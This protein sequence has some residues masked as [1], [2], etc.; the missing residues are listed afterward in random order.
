MVNIDGYTEPGRDRGR[1]YSMLV[2]I[3]HLG[4][5]IKHIDI[6]VEKLERCYNVKNYPLRLCYYICNIF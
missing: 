4:N 3:N 2:P 6:Y 1:Y 5:K